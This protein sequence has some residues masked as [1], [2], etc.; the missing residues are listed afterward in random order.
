MVDNR[1]AIGSPFPRVSI[2]DGAANIIFGTE[3]FSTGNYLKQS[4][5]ALFDV[6][7]FYKGKHS[8]LVGTDNE[9]SKST[10]IYISLQYIANR[11]LTFSNEHGNITTLLIES[12]SASSTLR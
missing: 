2:R 5:V 10:N 6:F 9:F 3:E 4:N 12:D 7:K 8:F 1:G 11:L